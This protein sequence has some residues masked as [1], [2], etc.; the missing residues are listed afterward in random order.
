MHKF[1]RVV[2]GCSVL[3]N[4]AEDGIE[5][6]LTRLQEY[7][8]LIHNFFVGQTTIMQLPCQRLDFG[9][10]LRSL[11]MASADL[12]DEVLGGD[13][14]FALSLGPGKASVGFD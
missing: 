8:T 4:R 7:F 5:R 12:F 13:A 11:L 1:L 10:E 2:D 9:D 3:V 14:F 6:W